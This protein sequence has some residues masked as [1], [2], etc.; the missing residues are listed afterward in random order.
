MLTCNKCMLQFVGKT[1]DE[2][3]F[4]WNN[5]KMN[6]RNFVKGQTCM[7][8]HLFEHFVNEGSFVNCRFLEDVT[9]TF[10]DKTDP[11]DPNRRKHYWRHTLKTWYF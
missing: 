5:Y 2:F 8:Q 7:Q 10:I 9:I 1:V 11:T 3:R 4:R 6:D